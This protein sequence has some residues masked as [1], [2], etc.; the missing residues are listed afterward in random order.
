MSIS[1]VRL[2]WSLIRSA[3]SFLDSNLFTLITTYEIIRCRIS[4]PSASTRRVQPT[5][6]ELR[7]V[8]TYEPWWK[9]KYDLDCFEWDRIP[10]L[11]QHIELHQHNNTSCPGFCASFWRHATSP[12]DQLRYVARTSISFV[13]FEEPGLQQQSWKGP[14]I[15][16]LL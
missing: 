1:I 12:S 6:A 5:T 7:D 11:Q 4:K 2:L 3:Y 13:E 9:N 15:S 10:W 8:P 16:L 14:R